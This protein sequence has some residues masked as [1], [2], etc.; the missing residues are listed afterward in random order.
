[1]RVIVYVEGKSD[2]LV[3]S[4]LLDDLLRRKREEGVL[5]TFYEAPPGNKKRTLLEQVPRNAVNILRYDPMSVVVALPDLYPMDIAFAHRTSAELQEGIQRN[6]RNALRQAAVDDQ[7]LAERFHVFCFK[8]DME[9]LVLAAAA[10]LA[11]RLGAHHLEANWKVPV[12]EQNNDRP[13]KRVVEELFAKH[14]MKYRELIDAPL[15]LTGVDYMDLAERCPQ[16]FKPFVEF[17]ESL[18]PA[19][20]S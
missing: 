3:L 5:I 10:E 19:T 18:A 20:N 13:P 17:L 11:S 8:H 14:G 15:I 6:F 2:E 9:V 12:E 7:R 16:C 1:M 4:I